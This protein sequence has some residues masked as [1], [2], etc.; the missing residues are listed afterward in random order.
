METASVTLV[1]ILALLFFV[2]FIRTS[3]A[4]TAA[5]EDTRR[6]AATIKQLSDDANTIYLIVELYGGVLQNFNILT[7]LA[8]AEK[9]LQGLI[10]IARDEAVDGVRTFKIE[11]CMKDPSG[12]SYQVIRT[13]TERSVGSSSTAKM[14]SSAGDITREIVSRFHAFSQNQRAAMQSLRKTKEDGHVEA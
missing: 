4:L 11:E 7:S 1:V 10:N 5:R 9:V 13:V 2:L 8:V 6:K 14:I 12:S 3:N